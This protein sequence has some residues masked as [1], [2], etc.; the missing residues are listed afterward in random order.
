MAITFPKNTRSIIDQ[1]READGRQVIFVSE[2]KTDCPTCTIDPITGNSTN[3]FDPTCSGTGYI[4]TTSGTS[5]L[6][7]VT[8]KPLDALDWVRGGK[9]FEGDAMIQIAYT[10]E[11][12]NLIETCAYVVVDGKNFEVKN[13]EPRGV[14][15][16][17]RV[18]V[19]LKERK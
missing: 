7:H 9:L 19:S 11:N 2:L 3:P 13:K 15:E 10:P 18:L 12:I 14:A 6:A 8:N 4:Y 16:L 1:M 5:I 17:N